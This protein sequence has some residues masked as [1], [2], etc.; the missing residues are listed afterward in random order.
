[1]SSTQLAESIIHVTKQITIYSYFIVF[2]LGLVGNTFN[3]IIFNALKVFRRNQSA[4]CIVVESLVNFALLIFVLPF[5][6]TE[7]AFSTD[8]TQSS[9]VWRKLRPTLSHTLALISF[10]AVCFA[11]IDQY[12]LVV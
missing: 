1:M 2:A 10:S 8:T 9:I 3:V 11:A 6:V 12:L 7:Y 4:L 5:R